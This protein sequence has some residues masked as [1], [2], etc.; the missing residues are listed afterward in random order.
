MNPL[1]REDGSRFPANEVVATAGTLGAFD[2]GEKSEFRATNAKAIAEHKGPRLLI[3]AGPG[4]GRAF[5]SG[6]ASR[7]GLIDI[8]VRGS[9]SRRS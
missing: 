2:A 4:T 8:L 3:V 5:F 1:I 9:W 7:T 6:V